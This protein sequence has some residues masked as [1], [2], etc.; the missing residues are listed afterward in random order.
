[1]YLVIK[2][3]DA[4]LDCIGG[5][6]GE[7]TFLF[8]DGKVVL[9]NAD[10]AFRFYLVDS[11]KDIPIKKSKEL[12]E[13]T[14]E[15]VLKFN[16]NLKRFKEMSFKISNLEDFKK[17]YSKCY[18]LDISTDWDS[19]AEDYLFSF[20]SKE[21]DAPVRIPRMT[22]EDFIVF[23]NV[24]NILSSVKIPLEDNSEVDFVELENSRDCI[25]TV[26][27]I[28]LRVMKKMFPKLVAKSKLFLNTLEIPEDRNRGI[29]DSFL[30]KGKTLF[31]Y[32]SITFL[33]KIVKNDKI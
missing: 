11:V 19:A 33:G 16:Q 2:Y 1:M 15:L 32:N 25:L 7:N 3:L 18:L 28:R 27:D 24:V 10:N 23:D 29:Y 26:N 13:I 14:D 9:D 22:K 5:I 4:L 17:I 20:D 12:P 30:M 6:E 8:H 21:Y 31:K